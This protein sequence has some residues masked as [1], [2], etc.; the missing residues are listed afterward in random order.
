MKYFQFK[1][2]YF[3]SPGQDLN[4]LTN[5]LWEWRSY[6]VT[7]RPSNLQKSSNEIDIYNNR[8][9][10]KYEQYWTD[11]YIPSIIRGAVSYSLEQYWYWGWSQTKGVPKHCRFS[12]QWEVL[13]TNFLCMY[14]AG[15]MNYAYVR[16]KNK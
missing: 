14:L 4:H 15:M 10:H 8:F 3:H 9:P 2:K 1:K 5:Q 6:A 16:K 11:W 12:L 7:T 13:A